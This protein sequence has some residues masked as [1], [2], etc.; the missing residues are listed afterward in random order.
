VARPL[1]PSPP[2]H[3]IHP[4]FHS[5]GVKRVVQAVDRIADFQGDLERCRQAILSGDPVSGHAGPGGTCGD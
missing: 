2:P 5:G 1:A 4:V 3:P